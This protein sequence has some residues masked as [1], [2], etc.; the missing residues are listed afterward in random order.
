MCLVRQGQST[1][2]Q[3][4]RLILVMIAVTKVKEIMN[5]DQIIT[6]EMVMIMVTNMANMGTIM[7]TSTVTT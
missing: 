7:T 6:M 5:T 3:Y 4:K 1:W 2:G